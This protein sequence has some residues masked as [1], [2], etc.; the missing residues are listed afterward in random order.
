MTSPVMQQKHENQWQ[1]QF[2][3]PS[4]Y[5]LSTLPKPNN[6]NIQLRDINAHTALVLRFS[7]RANN[8]RLDQLKQRFIKYANTHQIKLNSTLRYAFYNPPWTLPF[9]R[10]NEIIATLAD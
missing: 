7:G 8:Q 3:M 6:P 10:R 9:L 5:S 4:N 2:V 1:I